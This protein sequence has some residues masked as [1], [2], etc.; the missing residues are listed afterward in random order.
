MS[1]SL[2]YHAFGIRGYDYVRTQDQDGQVIFTIAQDPDDCRCSAC[3][4]REV[5]SRGHAARRSRNG[6]IGTPPPPSSSPSRGSNAA[7]AAPSVR[8]RSPAPT[9]AAAPP[10]PSRA[11]PWSCRGA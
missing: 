4:S 8:S 11:T 2:L 6:P 5:I 3:G 9:P 10:G 7:P 1:T